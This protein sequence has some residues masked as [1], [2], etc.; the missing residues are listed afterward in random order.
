M[1]SPSG[2]WHPREGGV[3]RWRWVF[4]PRAL[5]AVGTRLLAVTTPVPQGSVPRVRRPPL[6]LGLSGRSCPLG[7]EGLPVRRK[8]VPPVAVLAGL[9]LL[10]KPPRGRSLLPI[11]RCG[12][13]VLSWAGPKP[14]QTRDGHPWRMRPLFSLCPRAPPS[15][16]PP[17]PA[18]VTAG[19]RGGARR[20]WGWCGLRPD[21]ALP[22]SCLAA[23]AGPGSSDAADTLAGLS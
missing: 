16:A 23:L 2:L 17:R 15:P 4:Y 14:R 20:G 7:V 10:G 8:Q 6:S 22:P 12:D 11:D 3:G 19:A 13:L 1:V 18:V 21:P 9:L 5:H